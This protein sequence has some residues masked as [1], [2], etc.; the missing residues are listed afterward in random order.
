M[1]HYSIQNLKNI[2]A[3]LSILSDKH[4][5]FKLDVL[6]G[7]TIGQ[8]VR[9]IL[10]F[11]GCVIEGLDS[12]IINYDSRQRNHSMESRVQSA[13]EVSKQLIDSLSNLKEDRQLM[14]EGNFGY[15]EGDSSCISS[16]LYRELAYNL[17]HSIHHQALIKIGLREIKLTHLID[18]CFGI[19]PATIRSQQKSFPG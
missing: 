9:H 19:A 11:Y 16:S 18:P 1:V 13:L 2:K 14:L 8:H 7:G 15:E 12:G 10:E 4:Y 6:S 5:H 3:L 17:E